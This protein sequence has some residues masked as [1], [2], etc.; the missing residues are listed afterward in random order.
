MFTGSTDVARIIA[1]RDGGGFVGAVRASG[2]R[3]A[4]L[5]F[6]L[7]R[8]ALLG[9]ARAVRTG[10]QRRPRADD[11][12]R[13]DARAE[14]GQSGSPVCG[15]GSGHRYRRAQRHPAAHRDDAYRRPSRGPGRTEWRMPPW[16]LRGAHHHRNRPHQ[17]TDARSIRPGA[18]RGALQAR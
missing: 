18:A 1:Q 15:R 4:E 16:H 17:R 9:A 8:P 13:R 5:G 2:V 12:A 14:R 10:R 7:G 3:R 6:R 11:A